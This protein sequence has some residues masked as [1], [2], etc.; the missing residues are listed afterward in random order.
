[1]VVA[2]WYGKLASLGDFASRRLSA[3][4][5][6]RWDDWLQRVIAASRAQLGNAWLDTYLTSPV[7]RFVEWPQAAGAPLHVGVLMPSVDK[8]GRYF[9]LCVA[10]P[11][12]TLPALEGEWRALVEWCDRIEVA[13]LATLDMK[14]SVQQFDDALLAL[15]APVPQQASAFPPAVLLDGLRGKEGDVA[16][17]FVGH[18]AIAVLLAETAALSLARMATSASFWWTRDAEFAPLVACARLPEAERFTAM[19]QPR[20][21]NPAEGA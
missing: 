5:V 15:P 12:P 19:L 11:L 14:H 10:A 18:D 20:P 2:G 3:E 7:W 9:P 4:F 17:R 21:Q 16:P 8:V 13:A 6:A 1:M